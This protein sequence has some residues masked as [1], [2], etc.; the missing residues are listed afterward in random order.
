MCLVAS[1]LQLLTWLLASFTQAT[2][3]DTVSCFLLNNS[4]IPLLLLTFQQVSPTTPELGVD[5]LGWLVLLQ[6]LTWLLA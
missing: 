1:L 5:V 2:H 6:L 4:D 3:L